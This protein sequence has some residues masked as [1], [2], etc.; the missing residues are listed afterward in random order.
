LCTTL[1]ISAAPLP[2]EQQPLHKF[3]GVIQ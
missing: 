3:L 2:E 1:W